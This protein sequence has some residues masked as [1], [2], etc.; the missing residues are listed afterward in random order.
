M[1]NGITNKGAPRKT[2][3]KARQGEIISENSACYLFEL[4]EPMILM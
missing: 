1:N 3:N 2:E 4:F